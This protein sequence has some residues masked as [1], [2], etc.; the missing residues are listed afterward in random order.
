MKRIEAQFKART[1]PGRVTL[2]AVLAVTACALL[3]T[4]AAVWEHQR[5]KAL[6]AQVDQLVDDQRHNVRP[7]APHVS[8]A[9]DASARQFLRE[10]GAAWAPMLRTLESG[11][12][13]GVTPSS[14]EF[15]ATDGS[16]RV[17]LNYADTTALMDYL[18]RIND[19]LSAGSPRWTL[20]ETR[21]KAGAAS[22][23]ANPG[24]SRDSGSVALIQSIWLE[25]AVA[26][27]SGGLPP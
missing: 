13:I 15:S 17:E 1:R 24:M 8:P 6:R 23:G 19:G 9:Y 26:D 16:A 25:P 14:L 27:P 12:M 18:G 5:V 7:P 11:A 3:A 4:G 2:A 21:M 10:R 20:S 22:M